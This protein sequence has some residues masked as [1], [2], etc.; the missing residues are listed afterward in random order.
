MEMEKKNVV[1]MDTTVAP[2]V[3]GQKDT[4]TE[5][6]SGCVME[7]P[8]KETRSAWCDQPRAMSALCL[9]ADGEETGMKTDEIFGEEFPVQRLELLGISAQGAP[10]RARKFPHCSK[11]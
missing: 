6:T 8:V 1:D 5:V 3:D 9:F 11:L 7:S 10:P 2:P 4:S